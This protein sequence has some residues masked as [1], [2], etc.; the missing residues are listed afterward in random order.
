MSK[1]TTMR[2]QINIPPASQAMHIFHGFDDAT[3]KKA[4]KG[5][6]ENRSAIEERRPFAEL[7]LSV[8]GADQEQD[9]GF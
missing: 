2:N 6:R 9:A 1:E 7:V 5:A 8:P 3:G 4:T